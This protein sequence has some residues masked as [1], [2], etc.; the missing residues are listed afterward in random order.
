MR[1]A[2]CKPKIAHTRAEAKSMYHEQNY[3]AIPIIDKEEKIADIY[4]GGEQK[5]K[6]GRH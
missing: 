3:V 6:R 1:A 5:A 4:T 2:N